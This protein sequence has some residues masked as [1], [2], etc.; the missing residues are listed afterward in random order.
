MQVTQLHPPHHDEPRSSPATALNVRILV[1]G[2]SE[3]AR[4]WSFVAEIIVM[5]DQLSSNSL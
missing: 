3:S 5:V 4:W 1:G 2:V